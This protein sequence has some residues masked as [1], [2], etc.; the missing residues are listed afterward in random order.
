MPVT[1]SGVAVFGQMLAR[2]SRIGIGVGG[3]SNPEDRAAAAL[4]GDGSP[5]TA[6]YRPADT[7]FP[8]LQADGTMMLRVSFDPDEAN[9]LWREY[10]IFVTTGKMTP[11]HTLAEVG[12][13]AAMLS[14]RV[15]A[16]PLHGEAK[17]RESWRTWVFQV[18]VRFR[19]PD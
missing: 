18:P 17:T 7:G 6:W 11:H 14:R 3:G 5:H 2:G 8:Q 10:C 9:F 19:S 16:A 13:G 15:P 12:R 1:D 4:G